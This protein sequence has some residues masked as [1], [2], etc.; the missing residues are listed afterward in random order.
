M[1][2]AVV[3]DKVHIVHPYIAERHSR[4]RLRLET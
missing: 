1:I 2:F 4:S 3:Y